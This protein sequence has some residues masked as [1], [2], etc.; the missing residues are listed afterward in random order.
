MANKIQILRNKA[1]AAT[2]EAAKSVL[3]ERLA[4]LND[5]EIAIARYEE[6]EEGKKEV[7]VLLGFS[8]KAESATSA[9]PYI[10][11]ADGIPADVQAE[12]TKL[13]GSANDGSDV[14]TIHGA[15]NYAKALVE[16]LD[17][18]DSIAENSFVA[19]V[20]E[21]DGKISV[22]K[23]AV[24]SSNKTVTI[25][26]KKDEQQNLTGELSLDVNIDG[27]TIVKDSTSG[28]LSVASSALTQYVGSNAVSVSAVSADN[29]KTISLGINTNDKVL[30]QSTSGLLASLSL[31]YDST[32]KKITLAGKGNAVISEI[33]T[34]D[35]VK[36]GMLNDAK[37]FLATGTSQE[38]TFKGGKHTF[39]DLTKGNHYIGFEFKTSD[40]TTT[41]TSYSYDCLDATTIIDVYV[42]GDGLALSDHTFSV[43]KD[44]ASEAFLSVS[45]NGVKVSGVQSAIDT[46]KAEAKSVVIK[47]ENDA[48]VSVTS[49]V[50]TT[51]SHTIYTIES[52]DT[53]SATDLNSLVTATG[54]TKTE[55][56][57]TTI[58]YT[59]PTKS[60]VFSAT[61]SVMSM[62]NAIDAVWNTIDC[63]TY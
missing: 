27:T 28:V 60:G 56:E 45:S 25:T 34:N 55:G 7:K 22:K 41:G 62:L 16:A 35:F 29:K 14:I 32:N 37:A 5:G 44:D 47:K 59:A 21:T 30:S 38:I 58:A 26:A 4:T 54:L 2:R 63:G 40:G 1:I 23:G 61:T 12:I 13:I 15:R 46:A 6:G 43:K 33:A 19:S 52:V 48:H 11:D 20:S 51:D 8:Y 17:V 57:T 49:S 24:T 3:N 39:T 9:T 50:D 31:N 53:A 36:D 18:T 42:A 10:F